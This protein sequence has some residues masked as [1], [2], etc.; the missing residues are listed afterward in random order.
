[1]AKFFINPKL[2][3]KGK[4]FLVGILKP[5]LKQ[6]KLVEVRNKLNSFRGDYKDVQEFL[7]A[8]L[9]EETYFTNASTITKAEFFNLPTI[10][11]IIIPKG[12]KKIEEGAFAMCKC[13]EYVFI[14]NTVENI[15]K[16]AFANCK[17]LSAVE[18]EDGKTNSLYIDE[19]AFDYSNCKVY[20]DRNRLNFEP[21]GVLKQ[22]LRYK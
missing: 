12:I 1:M 9:G 16:D 3:D 14:S 8:H 20:V 19:D 17:M 4:R 2:S 18:I 15:E 10:E 13:L 22:Q 5:L 11:K 21:K 6:N 7:L